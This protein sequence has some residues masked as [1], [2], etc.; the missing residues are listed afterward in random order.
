MRLHRLVLLALFALTLPARGQLNVGLVLHQEQFLPGESIPVAV[1]ITN[2]S[3]QTLSMGRDNS[4]LR[5][6]LDV[7]DG[8]LPLQVSEIPVRGEFNLASST[9]ATKR[10]DLAPHFETLRP[11]RYILRAGVR[12]EAWNRTVPAP[13]IEFDVIQGTVLWEQPF[14]VPAA[15]GA[16]AGPE[17]RRYAL[18]QAIHLKQMKLYVR[19]TDNAGNRIFNVFPL[20]PMLTFSNPEQQIDRESKLHVLYQYGARS[21]YY[22]VINPDGQLTLRHTHDYAGTSRPVLGADEAGRIGVR[23]G[24]RREARDDFPETPQIGLLEQVAP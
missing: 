24:G 20:G 1:R 18:Q 23:G 17:I 12:I 5:F 19:V 2:F 16:E 11:G 9:I 4:W 3:G 8:R 14:G 15:A 22:C 10:A 6:T 21:F 7:K 13:P